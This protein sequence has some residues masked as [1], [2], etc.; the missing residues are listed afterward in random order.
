MIVGRVEQAQSFCQK[1]GRYILHSLVRQ[2]SNQDI[3]RPPST[4][5]LPFFSFLFW[6][7]FFFFSLL[8]LLHPNQ[9]KSVQ[10]R[11]PGN[12]T[13][14]IHLNIF[15]ICWCKHLLVIWFTCM[16]NMV[17]IGKYWKII[18]EMTNEVWRISNLCFFQFYMK[19][20]LI[21]FATEDTEASYIRCISTK[22]DPLLR[23]IW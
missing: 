23:S 2:V 4:L 11:S 20:A 7:F 9:I 14:Q 13:N 8:V 21:G 3:Y 5:S 10:F 22:S 12:R 6:S 16:V 17:D 15:Y 1:N 18:N 19:R